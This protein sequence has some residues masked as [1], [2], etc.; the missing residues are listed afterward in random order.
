[1]R[2]I[3]CDVELV[4]L[5]TVQPLGRT[6]HGRR[7]SGAPLPWQQRECTM[8]LGLI[9]AQ[10]SRAMSACFC[11]WGTSFPCLRAQFFKQ[12]G[13]ESAR[14]FS[15]RLALVPL[16]AGAVDVSMSRDR[17]TAENSSRTPGGLSPRALHIASVS[18]VTH[19]FQHD[20]LHTVSQSV[21]LEF[22]QARWPEFFLY[23]GCPAN[24]INSTS[25]KLEGSPRTRSPY[26]FL[27]QR[28]GGLVRVELH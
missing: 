19:G 7:C 25:A 23:Q 8:V 12:G 10:S 13:A 4:G 3:S 18:S 2:G 17:G 26:K 24:S 28:G 21:S 16:R 5:R 20:D 27:A 6:G 11:R 9:A 22:S 14:S 15:A 1:V